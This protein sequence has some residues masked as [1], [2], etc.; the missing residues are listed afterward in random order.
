MVLSAYFA[1]GY[2]CKSK[3]VSAAAEAGRPA[4][5]PIAL[6]V[7][8]TDGFARSATT[9]ERGK[10]SKRSNKLK[11]VPDHDTTASNLRRRAQAAPLTRPTSCST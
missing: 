9:C 10:I 6:L 3:L 8:T 7:I 2:C 4:P 5:V 1:I 11:S